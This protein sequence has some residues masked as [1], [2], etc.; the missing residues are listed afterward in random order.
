MTDDLAPAPGTITMYGAD[1]CRDCR[2]TE[3]L[4]TDLGVEWTKIDV[5][6]SAEAAA[7]AQAISGRTNIPVVVFPDG[8][9]LVEPSDDAVREKLSL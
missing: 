4:L 5:E 7:Q 6:A 8:S 3:A 1:W 9:H 2:R